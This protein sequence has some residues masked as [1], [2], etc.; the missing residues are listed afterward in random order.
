MPILKVYITTQQ[1]IRVKLNTVYY[2]HTCVSDYHVYYTVEH[3]SCNNT[4]TRK[5]ATTK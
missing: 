1:A 2:V 4:S 5:I 3:L